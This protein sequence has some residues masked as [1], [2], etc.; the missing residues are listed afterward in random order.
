MAEP[1]IIAALVYPDVQLLDVVGPL[2][3]FNLAS[4]QLLDNGE[5]RQPAYRVQVIAAQ[6]QATRSM[7]GLQLAAHRDMQQPLDDVDTLIIPGGLTGGHRFY[8]DAANIRWVQQAAP[9]VRRLC[10]VCSGALLLA[11][12]GLLEGKRATTHW[13]DADQLRECYPGVRVA[14]QTAFAVGLRFRRSVKR[15]TIVGINDNSVRIG[16]YIFL[17]CSVNGCTVLFSNNSY[18][19]L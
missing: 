10:S 18:C 7:S 11:A 14:K 5:T 17:V 13:M 12:A 2:E 6:A 4:Q 3:A 16:R 8:E 1:R 15:S 19:P 9:R